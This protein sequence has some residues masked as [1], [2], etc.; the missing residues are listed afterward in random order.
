M[1]AEILRQA[2][3]DYDYGVQRFVGRAHL[4]EKALTKFS[5]DT[6]FDR[7]RAAY[8]AGDRAAL[9]AA[10]HECK[11]MCGNIGLTSLYEAADALVQ[12]L[13]GDAVA[14][15]ALD[16]A[17]ALLDKRYRAVHTAVAAAMEDTL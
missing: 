10:A 13:R 3:V 17:Y 6:T 4:Y 8:E 14:P 7:I 2:G 16:A 5:K 15:D 12:L 11:G 9:L 1:K